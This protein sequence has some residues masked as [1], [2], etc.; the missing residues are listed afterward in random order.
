MGSH[1]VRETRLCIYRPCLLATL[2]RRP[3]GACQIF[4]H[5]F[6]QKNKNSGGGGGGGGVYYTRPSL[7]ISPISIK[8]KQEGVRIRVKTFV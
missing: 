8:Y 1:P 7:P 3:I 6:P 2:G 4:S 5:N